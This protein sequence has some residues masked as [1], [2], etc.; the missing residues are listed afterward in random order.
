M[1]IRSRS[2]NTNS[3]I[4]SF[5][6]ILKILDAAAKSIPQLAAAKCQPPSPP[7]VTSLPLSY[8]YWEAS[9]PAA[10]YFKELQWRNSSFFFLIQFSHCSGPQNG[11]P[12]GETN[13]SAD[14]A[15]RS[16]YVSCNMEP[17]PEKHILSKDTTNHR[18][19]EHSAFVGDR[20]TYCTKSQHCFT[21]LFRSLAPLQL[22]TAHAQ[23]V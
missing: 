15:S 8:S 13:T 11:S 1:E 10:S 18:A 2:Q 9:N 5:L 14:E 20:L 3:Y 7:T 4:F 17:H 22:Y 16:L 23:H 12:W 19:F 6:S 21:Q